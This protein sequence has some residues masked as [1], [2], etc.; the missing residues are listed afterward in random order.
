MIGQSYEPHILYANTH[1][2]LIPARS[3]PLLKSDCLAV[4]RFI[5]DFLIIGAARSREFSARTW[6][7]VMINH[8]IAA[9]NQTS[10]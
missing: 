5:S 10:K 6:N 7:P 9:A 4:S 8:L 3:A 2:L 1:M